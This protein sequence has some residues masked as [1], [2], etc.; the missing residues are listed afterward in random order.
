MK[1][2]LRL[3]D[4]IDRLNETIGR[5]VCWFTLVVV[6]I[7]SY[8]A[9]ARTFDRFTVVA[10]SSNAYLELQWYLFSIVF[11]LGGAYTLRHD[12]HVRVD[13]IYGRLSNRKKAWIDV[14]GTVLFLLPFCGLMIWTSLPAVINSWAVLEDSPDPNGL[15]RYPIKTILPVAFIILAAQGVSII[16]KNVTLLRGG[17]E[18][19]GDAKAA[20]R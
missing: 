16:I 3:A 12:A 5:L 8:N 15:P 9:L 6:L 10:I 14:L 19:S 4:G 13:V 11:L 20:P 1:F 2:W 17:R 7:G 18:G